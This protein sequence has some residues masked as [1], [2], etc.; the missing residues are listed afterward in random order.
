MI[1]QLGSDCKHRK[2]PAN[3]GAPAPEGIKIVIALLEI[4]VIS[5]PVK[6]QC[7]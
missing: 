3:P 5:A 4:S 2:I 1:R 6:N 7:N